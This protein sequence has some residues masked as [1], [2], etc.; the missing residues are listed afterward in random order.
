MPA[1]SSI[2]RTVR[3]GSAPPSWPSSSTS[4]WGAPTGR[5]WCTSCW[6][7]SR[8]VRSTSSALGILAVNLVIGQTADSFARA[9]EVSD[10][11]IAM[12]GDLGDDDVAV[13]SFATRGRARLALG[14]ERGLA[15]MDR[16]QER[17]PGRL[18]PFVVLGT[19]Q[20]YAGAAHHWS[21]PQP[22]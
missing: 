6:R 15:D 4:P 18:P 10:R 9:I 5:I 12:A 13:L 14:D 2:R 3:L 11:A 7:T 22:S 19:R 20:W 1:P 8:R 17:G 16:A 21:G